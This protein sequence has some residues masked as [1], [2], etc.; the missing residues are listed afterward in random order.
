LG[1]VLSY[2]SAPGSKTV[3]EH[4]SLVEETL[5]IASARIRGLEPRKVMEEWFHDHAAGE[6]K[7]EKI[8]DWCPHL[9]VLWHYYTV[10][11][12]DGDRP[13]YHLM[14]K[15]YASR[16]LVLETGSILRYFP[17]NCS[18]DDRLVVLKGSSNLSLIRRREGVANVYEFVS[19]CRAISEDL[20]FEIDEKFFSQRRV[21]EITIV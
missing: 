8:P 21:E 12:S 16:F 15:I 14:R 10:E 5:L 19:D 13:W 6:L 3:K 18:I 4:L 2:V 7:K 11:D 20:N 17:F 9:K 1:R